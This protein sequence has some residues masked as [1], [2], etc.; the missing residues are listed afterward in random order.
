MMLKRFL[1]ATILWVG[2]FAHAQNKQL[3]YDFTEIPLAL[4]T[5]YTANK[6][7]LTNIGLG[8]NFQAGP[9]NLYL[10]ADNLLAYRNI[11]AS[12]YTSFQFGLNIISWDK[13]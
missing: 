12:N 10:M 11:A 5:T 8:V 6:F 2:I 9:I 13:K 7:T 1:F 3:L 4:K